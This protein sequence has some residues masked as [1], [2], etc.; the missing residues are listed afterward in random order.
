M[1]YIAVIGDIVDS[2]KLQNRGEVQK[3]LK[4]VLEEVNEK[5]DGVIASK[6]MITL[7][8]EFQGLLL[9]DADVMDIIFGVELEMYPVRL[10]F[11]VGLGEMWTEIDRDMPLGADGPAYHRAR[12]AIERIKRQ[13]KA[14][15]AVGTNI[16]VM[17]FDGCDYDVLIN[18][19]LS[20]CYAIRSK[21]TARQWE[22]I[23]CYAVCGASQAE[24]AKKLGIAQSNVSRALINSGYYTYF[25]GI[26][27][28]GHILRKMGIDQN[29]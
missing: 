24:A 4:R 19:A 10:R 18:T 12:T 26:F 8:D 11:G 17:P 13:E 3:N 9:P 25:D 21:W 29:V 2:R 22:I 6:F 27:K 5:Y 15:E 16:S 20:L 1:R 28:V 14:N 7:G 23:R